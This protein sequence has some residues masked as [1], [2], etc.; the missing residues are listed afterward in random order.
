MTKETK[1]STMKIVM[2][3]DRHEVRVGERQ[4]TLPPAEWA[5]LLHLARAQGRMRT[6]EE[7]LQACW[8]D[9]ALD[10]D[11]RT[12]DQ[13]VARLRTRLRPSNPVLTVTRHGYR[14]RPGAV[15]FTDDAEIAGRIQL[16][17]RRFGTKR[18]AVVSLRV[19]G[20]VLEHL[21]RG[22]RAR[23]VLS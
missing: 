13:H 6:R 15:E 4:V 18:S 5:I 19:E 21:E 20:T 2:D 17:K 22:Q 16:V 12:V 3:A 9:R 23:L 7:I 1:M 10:V 11:T 8:G 14:I